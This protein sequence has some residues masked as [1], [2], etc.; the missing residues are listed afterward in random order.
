MATL[1]INN[2]ESLSYQREYNFLGEIFCY[3]SID[4]YTIKSRVKGT[5][6]NPE[7]S[8][9]PIWSGLDNITKNSLNYYDFIIDNLSLGSGKITSFQWDPGIDVTSKPYTMSF[10]IGSSGN[11]YNLT[12]SA[13]SD[14]S[15]QSFISGLRYV[16]DLQENV[17]IS[18]SQT[19]LQELQQSLSF[20]IKEPL[21][22]NEKL[23]LKNSIFS[24][25]FINR[26]PSGL[27]MNTYSMNIL[28]G[29]TSGHISYYNET[30][31][32]INSEYSF[33]RVSRFDNTN[34][35]ASWT[36]NHSV[37]LNGNNTSV[38]EKGNIQSNY[39]AGTGNFRN[40]SGARDKWAEVSTGIFKRISGTFMALSGFSGVY[41]SGYKHELSINPIQK[42]FTENPLD[43]TIS[44]S[45]GYTD[46]LSYSNYGYIYSNER[47]SSI[48]EDGYY[49]IS[50]RGN[51]K[52]VANSK[53][54][55]FENAS[56][57]YYTDNIPIRISGTF[58]LATG[59]NKLLCPS[60]GDFRIVNESTTFQEYEGVISYNK[61]YSNNPSYYPESSK[62]IKYKNIIRDNPP[63]HLYKK[64]LIP[65]SK[66]E[67][68]SLIQSTEGSWNNSITILGKTGVSVQ[69]Y[70]NEVFS[71]VVLPTGNGVLN[72]F[73][74]DMKYS[75][76]P[77]NNS[78]NA[79]FEYYYSKYRNATDI[80]V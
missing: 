61:T 19:N 67:I 77:F 43:G 55:R 53:N 28:T 26:M 54:K 45:Y 9:D 17:S 2:I 30:I 52:G 44:Y 12:G 63:V 66:E 37:Q 18:L 21:D 22:L 20:G 34:Q 69:E 13:Y 15:K 29:Q 76:D 72:Y 11:L 8:I 68:Q 6:S 80:L 35:K 75:F 49:N 32:T 40:L 50:E 41:P 65:S 3:S 14:I 5:G 36:Y 4:S 39:F 70:L 23:N 78:F 7:A 62:F 48:D 10:E 57:A 56:G 33:Q 60:T 27:G 47:S 1:S 64:I 24:G 58:N 73:L 59:V 51:Y 31:D 25:F 38:I 71:K 16:T 42:S 79:S 46:A 74:R